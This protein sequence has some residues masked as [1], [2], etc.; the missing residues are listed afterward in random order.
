MEIRMNDSVQSPLSF[1]SPVTPNSD[2][3]TAVL[4]TIEVGASE[5][6]QQRRMPY[7]I[8]DLVQQSRLGALRIRTV[9]GGPDVVIRL[10]DADPNLAHILRN[11]FVTKHDYNL[12]RHW[13]NARPLAS[14]NPGTYKARAIGD[15]VING[16][17]LPASGFF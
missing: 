7:D 17:P 14:H 11:H 3:L 15:H 1:P 4:A 10:G 8:I 9:H 2:T 5:R 16:S 13:R 6:V 12:D